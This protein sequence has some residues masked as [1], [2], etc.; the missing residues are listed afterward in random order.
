MIRARMVS[1]PCFFCT[2]GP[3]HCLAAISGVHSELSRLHQRSFTELSM[4]GV[5]A[6]R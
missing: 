4:W 6:Q 1:L 2:I 5:S 3:L